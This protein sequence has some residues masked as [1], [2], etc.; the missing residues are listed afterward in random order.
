MYRV[1][2]MYFDEW[3]T[4]V[5]RTGLT[6]KQARRHCRDPE[7]SSKTCT[8]PENKKRTEEKGP[9]FDGYEREPRRNP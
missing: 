6:L 1:V 8:R 7:T 3:P 4:E 5:I 2:R 9:W